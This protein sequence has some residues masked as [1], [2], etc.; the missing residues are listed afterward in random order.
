MKNYNHSFRLEAL[1]LVKNLKFEDYS[2]EEKDTWFSLGFDNLNQHWTV[3]PF[4]SKFNLECEDE[5]VCELNKDLDLIVTNFI[6][7]IEGE[8]IE[9]EKT[10]RIDAFNERALTNEFFNNKL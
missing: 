6:E 2:I 4:G 8:A 5:K 9:C 10:R 3:V 1:E 7:S